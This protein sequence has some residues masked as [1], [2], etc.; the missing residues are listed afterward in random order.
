MNPTTVIVLQ[1]VVLQT[2]DGREV[3]INPAQVTS[4]VSRAPSGNRA[5]TDK[6]QCVIN[7]TDGKFIT[8][9]EDCDSVRRRLEE[10]KR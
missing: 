4:V 7:L 2:L 5:L 9:A 10:A 3:H 8:V 1:L 6:A